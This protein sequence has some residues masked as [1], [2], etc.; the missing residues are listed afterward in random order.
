MAAGPAE[1]LNNL[2][3]LAEA[4]IPALSSGSFQRL[5]PRNLRP[6]NGHSVVANK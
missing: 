1:K 3:R 6:Q 5:F 2:S 4:V